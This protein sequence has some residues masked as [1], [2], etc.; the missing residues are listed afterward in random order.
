[1]LDEDQIR[2][3]LT[4]LARRAPAPE[5]LRAGLARGAVLRRQRRTMLL[6]G[7]AVAAGVAV[8]AAL[9]GSRGGLPGT[10]HPGSRA[11]TAPG[12]PLPPPAREPAVRPGNTRIALRYR[13]TWLPDGFVESGRDA[14]LDRSDPA[15]Q[16]RRWSAPI[17]PATHNPN[18]VPPNVAVLVAPDGPLGAAFIGDLG[19]QPEQ[20]AVN[21]RPAL[22]GQ[23]A[24]VTTVAWQPRPGITLQVVTH[25]VVDA[26]ATALRVAESVVDDPG[27]ATVE[28]A[29][30]FGWLPSFGWLPAEKWK[31][32]VV[33]THAD[34][35]G[36]WSQ[37]L[38][39]PGRL[40]VRYG[41]ETSRVT[42][43]N[44]RSVTVRGT[45]GLI[46]V[47]D[48]G[49]AT[50]LEMWLPDRIHLWVTTDRAGTATRTD[51]IR[52]ADE[53]RIGSRPY[54]GWIGGR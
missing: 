26:L 28:S 11:R 43:P 41:R 4:D 47:G 32:V 1:M 18:T 13:P 5:T 31:D 25:E 36:G 42:G 24:G 16:Q 52:T 3:A 12:S 51:L 19:S 6:A 40:W 38:M 29:L 35:G 49:T 8:P 39:L 30:A 53:L 2:L 33:R 10:L 15:Y 9:L 22:A 44:A 17:D 23:V 20:V 50:A 46:D 34:P 14:T 37:D 21:G 45:A 27:A 48:D 54:L 7:G